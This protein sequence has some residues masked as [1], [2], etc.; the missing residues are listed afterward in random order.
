MKQP[1]VLTISLVISM[2][3]FALTGCGSS[4]EKTGTAQKAAVEQE[5]PSAE[6]ETSEVL[7][8]D[9]EKP[10]VI[11]VP[12][13]FASLSPLEDVSATT[14]AVLRNMNDSLYSYNAETSQLE[15][16]L[17]KSIEINENVYTIELK[18]GMTF[19]NGEAITTAD[20]E[21]SFR[22]LAGEVEGFETS[23]KIWI[24]L[25]AGAVFDIQSDLKMVITFSKD[26]VTTKMGYDILDVF[27][28]P[29]NVAE[30]EQKKAPVGAGP[31]QFVAYRPGEEIT[32]T[33]FEDYHGQKP[34]IKNATFTILPE[35]ASQLLAFENNEIDWIS[36]TSKEYAT[37]SSIT[38]AK[39]FSKPANDVRVMHMNNRT[40]PFNNHDIRMAFNMAIDKDRIINSLTNQLG[41]KLGSHFSPALGAYWD[42]SLVDV[43]EYNT[44]GAKA[45]MEKNG[46]SEE[47]R[48]SVILNTVAENQLDSDMAI[49]IKDNLSHI[50]VDVEIQPVSWSTYY[51]TIYTGK[52]FKLALLHVVGFPDPYRVISRYGSEAS[53]NM[54]G[55][56]NQR[57]DQLS[58]SVLHETDD[59]KRVDMYFKMQQILTEEAV[60]VFIMD[61]G[62]QVA[63][64]KDYDHYVVYPFAFTDLSKITYRE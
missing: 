26:A 63:L 62:T 16:S 9:L 35:S 57:F 1:K 38:D 17:A 48:L 32:M 58:E 36:I 42:R 15:L 56:Q 18:E 7:I 24:E 49:L 45:I 19:H 12:M 64:S 20:V 22:R 5:E 54:P 6:S 33:R 3:L 60:S 25:L 37:V 43:Y 14:K 8:K 46:Y 11:P 47:N 4:E 39:I 59:E 61:Q 10:I 41:T 2:I 23:S 40:E 28:V 52:D 29:R 55:L 34:E 13:D 21:Y 51:D 53:G 50:Y 30:A 31:Y 27:I 44:E